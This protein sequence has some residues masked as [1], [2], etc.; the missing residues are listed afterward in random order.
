MAALLPHETISFKEKPNAP[1][2]VD[3]MLTESIENRSA[4]LAKKQGTAIK[5]DALLAMN[6]AEG[7]EFVKPYRVIYIYHNQIDAVGDVAVTET[8]T[9]SAVRNAINDMNA[10]IRF[11]INSLNGTQVMITADHGFIY[12]KKTPDALDKSILDLKPDGAFKTKKRYII[13]KPLFKNDKVWHGNTKITAF[14]ENE[15][16]FWIPKGTNRFHFSRWRSF[17]SRGC[18]ASRNR[19]ASGYCP[20]NEGQTS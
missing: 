12:Q 18:N 2:L 15:M 5:A 4:I 16:E 13:G 7:R 8:K 9:F 11:I 3:D 10:L 20:G 14:T 1:V 17:L 19:S 6:K